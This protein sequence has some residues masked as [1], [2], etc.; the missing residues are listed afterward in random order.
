MLTTEIRFANTIYICPAC[1]EAVRSELVYVEEGKI[2]RV[3]KRM[4]LER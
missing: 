2:C 1:R 4:L 3:S